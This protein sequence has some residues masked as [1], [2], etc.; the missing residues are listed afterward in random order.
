MDLDRLIGWAREQGASDLHLEAGLPA[1]LRVRGELKMAGERVA[2]LALQ[3]LARELLGEARWASFVEQ[4][5]ADFS[6]TVKG[7]RCRI[8]I[9]RSSRGVGMAIRL[10]GAPAATLK[11][12]NL[13]PGLLKLAQ[14]E[15]GLVLISGPAGSGK[16][17]TANALLQ[18][19]NLRESR[20]IITLES[21][22]E[23]SLAPRRSLI[24]QREVGRDTPSF[25]QGLFDAMR[26]DPD[27][28][29]V[30]EMREPEVM[31]LTLN[32]A[33]TGHLVLATVHSATVAEALQR[34]VAA[35]PAEIQP[36]VCAQLG[37]CLCGVVAQRLA[38]RRD[39][40]MRVPE[41][42]ILTGTSGAKG[43]IRQSQFFKLSTVVESGAAEGCFS[44]ARYRAWLDAKQDWVRPSDAVP[45]DAAPESAEELPPDDLPP[46]ARPRAESARSAGSTPG[47]KGPEEEGVLVLDDAEKDLTSVIEE[48]EHSRPRRGK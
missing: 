9:L 37:D 27:V 24:R 34:V 22:I 43:L 19:I 46:L 7:V 13:H 44:F 45:E 33:E 31:R 3:E 21:P 35:F 28:L 38:F 4:R 17:S 8:N 26:E 15:N 1:T 12:L 48:L 41:C 10:L 42:E 6:R 47:A 40:G 5:S 14:A 18:E 2:A 29:F 23:Y 20:H 39:L 25:E 16:T 30:G 32:A 11:R 36:G